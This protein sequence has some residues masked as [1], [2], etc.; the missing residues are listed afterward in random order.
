MMRS[1]RVILGVLVLGMLLMTLGRAQEPENQQYP[2]WKIVQDAIQAVRQQPVV[3]S[4]EPLT[5]AVWQ[6]PDE[7]VYKNWVPII[8]GRVLGATHNGDAI[9]VVISKGSQEIITLRKGFE[10]NG[11]NASEDFAFDAN[12]EN[13]INAFGEL[14]FTFKFYNDQT[15]SES[16]IGVRNVK[17]VRCAQHMGSFKHVWKFGIISDDLAGSSSIWLN[18][19]EDYSLPRVWIYMWGNRE[20]SNLTDVSVRVEVDSQRL[21]VPDDCFSIFGDVDGLQQSEELY[22]RDAPGNLVVNNYNLS[23]FRWAP[24]LYWGPRRTDVSEDYIALIDHPGAWVVKFRSEGKL[25]RELHFT[26][27]PDGMI[28]QHPEQD[29]SKPGA[30]NLGPMRFFCETYFGNPNEFDAR[31]NPEA[32]K[33][34][35]MW[36][37]PWISAE[38]RDGMLKRLPPAVR[39]ARPFPTATL[40]H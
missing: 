38:V 6:G 40:P 8:H 24:K 11:E 18:Q 25:M 13:A 16:V 19:E 37:R 26:V 15:E 3:L 21:T 2:T 5:V 20:N 12:E 35:M 23:R 31:F 1:C 7:D 4:A 14:T 29:Q 9:K 36:G 22:L 33:A 17:V 27:T 10:G 28:A 30:L 39:G 34:G 32:I